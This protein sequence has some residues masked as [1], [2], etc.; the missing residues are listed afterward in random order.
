M[1][2]K[3]LVLSIVIFAF[4]FGRDISF[5]KNSYS[6]LQSLQ[7]GQSVMVD[8]FSPR[9]ES[10]RETVLL[11][12]WDFEDDILDWVSV[13]WWET[14]DIEYNSPTHSIN[15]P[16]P[17]NGE[18]SGSWAI[19]SPEVTLPDVG[20]GE[21]IRF[22]FSLFADQVDSDGDGDTFLDDYYRVSL[23]DIDALA[24]HTS[25][26]NAYS[27]DSYW[28]GYEDV[29]GYLDGWLQFL[30][31]PEFYVPSTGTTLSAQLKWG[32]EDPA[33]AGGVEG[34]FIDGWD[35]ANVRISAD[36]GATWDILDGSDPYD[37]TSG[38]GWAYNG[39]P[40]YI[41]GWGGIQDWHNV[42]FNLDAYAGM[43]V[44]VR[45]AFGSDPAYSVIDD[46]A[47]IGLFIDD[48]MVT[49]ATGG[50]LFSSNADDADLM[51]ATGLVWVDQFYDYSG[52]DAD[53]RPGHYGWEDYLPG[54]PFCTGCNIFLDLNGFAGKTI[55]FKIVSIYDD[56]DDGGTG[57]GLFI[58]DFQ[59]YKELGA[60]PAPTG[61]MG[62][63]LNGEVALTWDDM[64][65]SGTNDL[66]FDNDNFDPNNGIII[67]GEG[68][69][70][71]GAE[72]NIVGP[73]VINTVSYYNVNNTAVSV[74]IASYSKVG[75]FFNTSPSNQMDV[76][77]NTGWNDFTLGWE[78]NSPFILSVS[79]DATTSAAL[80]ITAPGTHSMVMLG[81]SWDTWTDIVDGSGGALSNGEWGIRANIT[82]YGA[83]VTYNVY[84]DGG[85][86]ASDLSMNTYSDF[87]V[88]NNIT[89][90]YGVTAVF[91]SG[92][93]SEMS[94]TIEITPQSNTVHELAHDD[95]SSEVGWQNGS[96]NYTA[97]RF[98][99][100][101]GGEDVV[102]AKWFQIGNGGAFYLYLWEDNNG[103]PGTEI[104]HW[105]ITSGING[106]NDFDLSTEGIV[107]SGD[108]WLG[109]REFSSSNP[110]GLDTDSD[111]GNTYFRIGA[112][113][114]WEALS[115]I[116]ISGNLMLRVYLDSGELTT[117]VL[118]D[119]NMD[120]NIDVLD[121]VTVV[122]F[123]MGSDTPTE[124]EFCAADFNEDGNIDVL[125]IVGIV[126]YIMGPN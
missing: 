92:D 115:S 74:T 113:G 32:L 105:I 12:E 22:G 126:N 93:E 72:F 18:N 116:G 110:F 45:F 99:A 42:T 91:P 73:S 81:G 43:D 120:S 33:G 53:P 98:N 90:V 10:S 67:N 56:N 64:N 37:F 3:L 75:A 38:Y 54:Y 36:G 122:N 30:D 31:S 62:E 49:D 119:V 6:S 84:R 79:F 108:F 35:A 15:S 107:I 96:G 34:H 39:E 59:I 88:A 102:R 97:V 118:G 112:G 9:V 2:R 46:A 77:L 125:D 70:Q 47:L 40:D 4:I 85:M 117:C 61:L 124:D 66:V 114:A 78:M 89:Y 95:G 58:D 23:A 24:W 44:I 100:S 27:G 69:A 82:Q 104:D 13:G 68:S 48:V 11:Y 29:G 50:E 25:S 26:F 71:A 55:K 1:F 57:G 7:N 14:T 20:E 21:V 51:S 109:V 111:S 123:I 103:L 101:A 8:Q 87:D 19:F 5:E 17:P 80:D 76:T 52:D 41:P 28:C 16:N 121:I 60:P 65:Y 83:D 106:W 86:V 63:A 94:E